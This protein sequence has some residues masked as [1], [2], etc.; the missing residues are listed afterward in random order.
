[1]AKKASRAALILT[2]VNT[3]VLDNILKVITPQKM[4]TALTDLYDTLMA[5]YQTVVN[6]T[7]RDSLALGTDFKENDIVFVTSIN[8]GDTQGV[9]R[10]VKNQAG[11]YSWLKIGE[12]GNK[13]KVIESAESTLA[14]YISN[15]YTNGDLDIGY[16]VKLST[17]FIYLVKAND[18]TYIGDTSSDYGLI[19]NGGIGQYHEV[20][21]IAARNALVLNTDFVIGDKCKVANCTG[22]SE[23]GYASVYEYSYNTDSSDYDWNWIGSKVLTQE[24]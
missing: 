3:N 9:Y 6:I 13:T 4:R 24:F 11:A 17:G 12:L 10:Y 8:K 7:T 21:T 23:V 5:E 1:M 15:D 2:W 22:S 14:N 18:G 20:A 19:Y 16:F